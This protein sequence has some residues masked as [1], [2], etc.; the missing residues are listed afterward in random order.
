MKFTG[1]DWTELAEHWG[2][3]DEDEEIAL[4][5][6]DDVLRRSLGNEKTMKK[7]AGDIRRFL[8][9]LVPQANYDKPIWQGMLAIAKHKKDK[10]NSSADECLIQYTRILLSCMW[11]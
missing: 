6:C 3:D 8:K 7:I 4:Q 11:S 9:K 5:L 1:I 10:N 2:V